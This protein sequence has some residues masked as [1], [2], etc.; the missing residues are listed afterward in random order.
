MTNIWLGEQM[1]DDESSGRSVY[2]RRL[3]G[4]FCYF[5]VGFQG[6]DIDRFL[7][8]VGGNSLSATNGLSVQINCSA[9]GGP[10]GNSSQGTDLQSGKSGRLGGRIDRVLDF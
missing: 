10:R 8:S 9:K 6:R 5:S 2:R 1:V 7:T 3:F 4:L